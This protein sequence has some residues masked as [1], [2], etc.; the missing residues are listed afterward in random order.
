MLKRR[1]KGSRKVDWKRLLLR[2]A[3]AGLVK[4]IELAVLAFMIGAAFKPLVVA[5]PAVIGG[6]IIA[7]VVKIKIME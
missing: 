7:K 3:E 1:R 5:V 6:S 4:M 2:S